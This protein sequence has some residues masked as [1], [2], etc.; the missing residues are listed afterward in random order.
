MRC[1]L[2]QFLKFMNHINYM[3]HWNSFFRLFLQNFHM[4]VN[5][6][7]TNNYYYYTFHL[8]YI[9]CF[10]SF[11]KTSFNFCIFFGSYYY[12]SSSSCDNSLYS[13]HNFPFWLI[14]TNCN[15]LTFPFLAIIFFPHSLAKFPFCLVVHTTWKEQREKREKN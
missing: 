15:A 4:T 14:T 10:P 7:I 2:Y 8:H 5:I 13:F 3:R 9:F 1:Y 11:C 6:V 12:Y